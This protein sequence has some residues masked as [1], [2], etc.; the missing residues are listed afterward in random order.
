M[1]IRTAFLTGFTYDTQADHLRHV[2]ADVIS[3]RSLDTPSMR[4]LAREAGLSDPALRK[5]FGTKA[6]LHA[7][8]FE[9]LAAQ[10]PRQIRG[11]V[12]P[13]A[14]GIR[15][16]HH[17]VG[18]L[19]LRAVFA[20]LARTDARLRAI[21]T[22]LEEIERELIVDEIHAFRS[23]RP[24]RQWRR[25]ETSTGSVIIRPPD[26]PPRD[27]PPLN[28]TPDQ[29]PPQADEEA[30]LGPDSD[31]IRLLHHVLLGLW[32]QLSALEDPISGPRARELWDLACTH[33]VPPG[34][35]LRTA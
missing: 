8:T 17:L 7:R 30:G 5:W 10:L 1:S 24:E 28:R 34:T 35:Q 9:A 15:P 32:A 11:C 4:M 3:I 12:V 25:E 27:E 33:I 16:F 14:R 18:D 13:D 19:R 26:D 2:L 23:P 22:E 21:L 20:E 31:E 29:S 6:E